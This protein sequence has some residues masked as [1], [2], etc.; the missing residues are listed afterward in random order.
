MEMKKL[1]SIQFLIACLMH[2]QRPID[3]SPTLWRPPD[4]SHDVITDHLNRNAFDDIAY[5]KPHSPAWMEALL[6]WD[7]VTLPRVL[8]TMVLDAWMRS[9]ELG[10]SHSSV[11]LASNSDN[12]SSA[13]SFRQN[14]C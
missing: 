9:S 14:L 3:D 1:M 2:R 11:F 10:A 6:S 4:I 7:H 8:C 13:V 12:L 5:S